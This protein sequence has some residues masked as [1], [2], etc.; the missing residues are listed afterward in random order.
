MQCV[1]LDV[2]LPSQGFSGFPVPFLCSR[3]QSPLSTIPSRGPR[4]PFLG[5]QLHNPDPSELVLLPPELSRHA[6]SFNCLWAPLIDPSMCHWGRE[7]IRELWLA[8]LGL[9]ELV[10]LSFGDKV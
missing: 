1:G 5:Q 7:S 9:L 3:C 4:T 10:P 6:G 8:L 2:G